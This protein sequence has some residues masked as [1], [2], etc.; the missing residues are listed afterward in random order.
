MCERSFILHSRVQGHTR[1][2]PYKWVMTLGLAIC[3]SFTEN[4]GI[5]I[6][7]LSV[8]IAK[9]LSH[10]GYCIKVEHKRHIP[11]CSSI[12]LFDSL[13][14]NGNRNY[15]IESSIINITEKIFIK[16]NSS[17]V[18]ISAVILICIAGK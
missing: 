18:F 5:N 14:L 8:H 9:T 2:R 1:S 17:I 11:V 7:Q 3:K 12:A 13:Q 16:M 4:N 15:I 10:N 6:F